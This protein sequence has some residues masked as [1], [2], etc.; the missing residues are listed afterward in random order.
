MDK[1]VI[2][3]VDGTLVKDGTLDI[4][5]EYCGVVKELMDKGIQVVISSGIPSSSTVTRLCMVT[6]LP[7]PLLPRSNSLPPEK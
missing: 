4:N 5:P 3:D 1:I 2:S 7:E 6:D